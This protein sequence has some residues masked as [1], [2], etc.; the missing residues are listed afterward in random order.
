MLRSWHNARAT[1]DVWRGFDLA[2]VT[3]TEPYQLIA[4]LNQSPFNV[5]EV[6]EPEDFTLEQT[7]E[8][9]RRHGPILGDADVERL[10]CL[11]G[12]HPYLVRRALYLI[13]TNR[14]D[15]A[16]L[17]AT[18]SSEGGPFRDHLRHHV[19]RLHER[20]EL[21]QGLVQIIRQSQRPNDD[22][23]RRLRGAGLIRERDGNVEARCRLYAEYFG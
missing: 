5:G 8:L 14:M 3:S 20:P 1:E 10:W 9:S 7:A 12:G 23:I 18:A 4:D 2:L 13:A 15:I 21:I 16:Q 19:Y 6:L 11:L 22:V 17:L